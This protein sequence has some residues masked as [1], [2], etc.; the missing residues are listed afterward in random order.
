MKLYQSV[1]TYYLYWSSPG[2]TEG[3]TDVKLTLRKH[4]G[5]VLLNEVSMTELGDGV[6]Q[7][8]YNFTD[9]GWYLATGRSVSLGGITTD[10]IRVGFPTNDYIYGTHITDSTVFYEVNILD[11]TNVM[12]G[13]MTQIG[14]T[15][16]WWTDITGLATGK[17]F[18]KMN[19][20]DTARFDYPFKIGGGGPEQL[21]LVLEPGFNL[22]AYSGTGNYNFD[23]TSGVWVYT[24]GDVTNTKSSDLY[25]YIHYFYPTVNVKYIKSY[26]EYPIQR[27]K[28]FIP[29]IT[30]V[31]NDN[32]FPLVQINQALDPEKNAFYIFLDSTSD[33]VI[34][35]K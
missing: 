30:P 11:D 7:Y 26:Y 14:T 28:V 17:Y 34:D 21:K 2:N 27:F 1:G 16:I 23:S 33:I 29:N 20:L 6:Y 13:L 19:H 32:N 9:I 18:F 31:T 22:S 10:S 5:T 4:D 25:N 12:S 15:S 24:S 3:L 8:P 35:C